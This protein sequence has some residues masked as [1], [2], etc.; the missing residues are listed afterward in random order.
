ME[1][2]GSA[3]DADVCLNP[4][5][6]RDQKQDRAVIFRQDVSWVKVSGLYELDWVQF[7]GEYHLLRSNPDTERIYQASG[8]WSW[9][10]NKR[11]S[12][13]L[14]FRQHFLFLFFFFFPSQAVF[15]GLL[16]TYSGNSS[17]VYE[18]N[19]SELSLSSPLSVFHSIVLSLR[20]YY[21]LKGS[22]ARRCLLNNEG[23]AMSWI[24]C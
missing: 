14:V 15:G 11:R 7:G 19:V 5:G 16:N 9:L 3:A 23:L 1:I 18:L 4:P 21:L 2:G 10:C 13:R 20:Y 17:R 24:S 12:V 8:L 6:E 22:I